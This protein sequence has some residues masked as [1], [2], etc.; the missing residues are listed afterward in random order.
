MR[1]LRPYFVKNKNKKEYPMKLRLL[2]WRVF[3]VVLARAL[4]GVMFMRTTQND[5]GSV[6]AQKMMRVP[7]G[8]PGMP[9]AGP[10]LFQTK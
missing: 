10:L 6:W 8:E 4:R 7:K 5:D 9:W 1:N 3:E 2:E